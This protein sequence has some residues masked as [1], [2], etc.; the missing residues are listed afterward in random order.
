MLSVLHGPSLSS[1]PSASA[2]PPPPLKLLPTAQPISVLAENVDY[3]GSLLRSV[4]CTLGWLLLLYFATAC[5]NAQSQ[6]RTVNA[7][8][9]SL[10]D[11]GAYEPAQAVPSGPRRSR[12]KSAGT[13]GPKQPTR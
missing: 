12:V 13:S 9:A 10:L 5:Y 3:S 6:A 1:L 7:E 8:P 2:A 4:V 11:A